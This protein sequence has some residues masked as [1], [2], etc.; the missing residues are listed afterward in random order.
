MGG[1]LR[2][3]SEG[4][5]WPKKESALMNIKPILIA[6]AGPVGLTLACELVRHGIPVRIV[7]RNSEATDK[8][9]ALVVWPRTLELLEKTGLTQRFLASGVPLGGMSVYENKH[10]RMAHIT[11]ADLE[12][13]YPFVLGIPQSATEALLIEHLKAQGVE[14]ERQV[15]VVGFQ[16]HGTH[17]EVDLRHADGHTEKTSTNWLPACDGARSTV[18]HL[19]G[20]TL[21]GDTVPQEFAM[22]DCDVEGLPLYDEVVAYTT[23]HGIAAFFPIQGMRMRAFVLRDK[24]GEEADPCPP[25]LEEMQNE[26]MARQLDHLKLSNAC[27]LAAFRINERHAKSYRH[28]RV[29][30]AGDAA[31]VHSPVGGQ[32]MNTG[33]QDAFNLGWKLA[34]IEK[35]KIPV[36]PFLDSYTKEREPIGA[37]VV[38]KTSRARKAITLRNPLAKG[39]RNALVSFATSFEFVRHKI[40]EEASEL[41]VRYPKSPLNREVHAGNAAWLL[42]HGVHPG[43]RA[44]D[45]HLLKGENEA[46]LFGLMADT[47]FHLLVLSGLT[48]GAPNPSALECARW[49]NDSLH[50]LVGVHWIG[51]DTHQLPGEL[52]SAW[53]DEGSL[54]HRRYGAVEATLYLVRP[55]GY[56]A[57]R[58]QPAACADLKKYLDDIG[59]YRPVTA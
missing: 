42:G 13:P 15:E 11:F 29:L 52:P 14:V 26:L 50:E 37:D 38:N 33:M 17:V 45:G 46:H 49:A 47:R 58:S 41:T 12:S 39:L 51:F 34:L 7:D 55:D 9:K 35:G 31:H 59:L 5:G 20:V 18:R 2:Q 48:P 22:V 27:W 21:E 56:V 53:W 8:S 24:C 3:I 6:G 32:G 28:G 54:I 25:T 36:D 10:K 19:L 57:F 4:P 23:A 1:D 30:L 43:D 44:P 16:Q 40:A